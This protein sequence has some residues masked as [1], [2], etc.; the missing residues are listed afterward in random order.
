M[1]PL[2]VGAEFDVMTAVSSSQCVR[3]L[4][5]FRLALS[6]GGFFL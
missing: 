2:T 5:T 3:F 6:N 4:P 1:I